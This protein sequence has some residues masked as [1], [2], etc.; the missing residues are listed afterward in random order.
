MRKPLA[1]FEFNFVKKPREAFTFKKNK[2]FMILT[3]KTKPQKYKSP[4]QPVLLSQ[5][6]P[7]QA[8]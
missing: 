8:D 5:S 7:I 6:S 1:A 2:L 3:L 4:K